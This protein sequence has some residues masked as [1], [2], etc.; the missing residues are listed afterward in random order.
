MQRKRHFSATECTP[1][2][3]HTWH[4]LSIG[5]KI[6]L[7]KESETLLETSLKQLAKNFCIGKSAV[8]DKE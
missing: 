1:L 3:E 2:P 4:E 6:L 7:V 5:D 8:D